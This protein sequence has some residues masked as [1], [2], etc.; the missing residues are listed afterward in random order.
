MKKVGLVM[1]KIQFA[2][3]QG[4][5]VFADRL[6]ALARE[7]GVDIVFISPERHVSEF[8]WLPGYEH[9]KGDLVNYDVVLD[10]IYN[11][12]IEHVIYTVSGFTFLNMFLKN[13][14]LFP[15]SF[16]DPALTGYEMMK[17]FYTMV[18]KAIVQTEFLKREISRNFGVTDTKVIPIGFDERLAERYY[19]PEQVVHNRILW[20]GRDEENRRPDIV[21]DYARHNPDKEVIMVFGGERYKQSMK[22]YS[23]PDNVK[24]KF[25]L[26]QEEVFQLMNSAKV[27]WSCSKFDTFAMP[28]TEALAMGKIVVKPEHPCY[29]HIS[30]QH[31]FS[32][33]EHNWFELVN[34]AAASPL[35]S[36]C[37][38]R[39][40]AFEKFSSQVM[41]QGYADFF[42][43]W[44][45]S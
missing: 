12:H 21:L 41:K 18:N 1:R 9:E 31:A 22:K 27:Y 25:A 29:D 42:D 45:S 4:P 14:V 28:L 26:T 30:A 32:G 17:P 24:L 19:D 37:E 16:P 44:L 5:K 33:N 13:S 36:S 43:Q 11:R 6:Q 39:A 34:M 20:M 35:K 23:I 7:L 38:N 40:Y 2:E 3:R 8:D 15:H 10:Q